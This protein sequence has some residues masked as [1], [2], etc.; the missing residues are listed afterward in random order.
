MFAFT[1]DW[2]AC[3]LS[4]YAATMYFLF[5]F[6]GLFSSANSLNLL[7]RSLS[8]KSGRYSGA[9]NF[10]VRDTLSVFWPG[11]SSSGLVSP[12]DSAT[13]SLIIIAGSAA[14]ERIGGFD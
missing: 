1:D 11:A 2:A 10:L 7:R 13:S 9:L 5:L 14:D 8:S 4:Q 12:S 6:A 3:S